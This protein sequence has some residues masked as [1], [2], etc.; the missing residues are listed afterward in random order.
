MTLNYRDAYL[1]DFCTQELEDIADEDVSNLGDFTEEWQEKLT[2]VRCYILA[3]LENQ[4]SPDDLFTA[5][6]KTYSKE[7]E[8]LLAQARTASP[9]S[10]G[11][12]PPI[13]SIPLE[14]S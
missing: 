1:Q 11:N 6:Y 14:R 7:F 12:L 8:G 4:A 2:V 9:D 10:D 13:F 3:C 5:K